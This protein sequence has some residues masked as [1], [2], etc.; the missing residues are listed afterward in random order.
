MERAVLTVEEVRR[1]AF[2]S[3]NPERWRSPFGY[4]STRNKNEM[5]P[6]CKNEDTAVIRD[7][8][9]L[10]PFKQ[11]YGDKYKFVAVH[12][13]LCTAVWSYWWLN[14]EGE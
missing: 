14:K 3:I 11:V 1:T 4:T 6:Y 13:W 7:P 9:H 5:C 2:S 10:T 12:C 8:A